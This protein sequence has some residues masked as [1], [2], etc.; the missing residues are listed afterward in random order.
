MLRFDD[1]FESD[2]DYSLVR[3]AV[4][5]GLSVG[6]TL[7]NPSC[8]FH[9]GSSAYPCPCYSFGVLVHHLWFYFPVAIVE[10]SEEVEG[11]DFGV[12]ECLVF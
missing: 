12:P 2:S 4:A 11:H 3:H 5:S 10:V 9:E 7:F 6:A 8:E 1:D